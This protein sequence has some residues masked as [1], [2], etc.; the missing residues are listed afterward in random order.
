MMESHEPPARLTDSTVDL[1]KLSPKMV[2]FAPGY[3]R[4]GSTATTRAV[5]ETLTCSAQKAFTH[6]LSTS[7]DLTFNTACVVCS[8]SDACAASAAAGTST[9]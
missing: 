3:P 9:S 7:W 5:D 8:R 4:A 6:G 1:E 2:T